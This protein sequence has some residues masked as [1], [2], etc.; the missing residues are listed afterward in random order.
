MTSD[1]YQPENDEWFD[2]LTEVKRG[3]RIGR[4]PM[5][6]QPEVLTAAGH[7]PRRTRSIIAA[8]GDE[9]IDEKIVRHKDLRKHCLSCSDNK[10]SEVVR[11][12]AKSAVRRCTIIDCPFWAYRMGRNPHNPRRGRNPFMRGKK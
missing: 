2:V 6:I 9:P 8:L 4:N 1:G 7:G 5:T 3:R 11:R 10:E 12:C